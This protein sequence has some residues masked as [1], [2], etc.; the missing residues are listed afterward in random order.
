MAVIIIVKGKIIFKVFTFIQA[1]QC[2]LQPNYSYFASSNHLS[3]YI[4]ESYDIG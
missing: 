3:S 1:I 4:C 2:L